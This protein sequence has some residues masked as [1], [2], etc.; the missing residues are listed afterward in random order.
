[1]RP[2]ELFPDILDLEKIDDVLDDLPVLDLLLAGGPEIDPPEEDATLQE[3][4]PPQHEI[5]EHGHVVKESDVLECPGDPEPRDLIRLHPRDLP[6][7]EVDGSS[8][9]AVDTGDAVEYRGL[10]GA[11]R[12]DDRVDLPFGHV[13][14]DPVDRLHAPEREVDVVYLKQCHP[15]SPPVIIFVGYR[16]RP[17]IYQTMF[18][19][20]ADNG[21]PAM[22]GN[23]PTDRFRQCAGPLRLFGKIKPLTPNRGILFRLYYQTVRSKQAE[24]DAGKPSPVPARPLH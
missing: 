24:T 12:P 3:Q 20:I 17:V 6:I 7:L 13:G 14:G 22:S 9:G 18:F 23:Y 16:N 10:P 11:I 2:D 1:M 21:K 19:C 8:L 15:G 5:V 4:V